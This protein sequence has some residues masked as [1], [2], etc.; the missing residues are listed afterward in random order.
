ML[1]KIIQKF[2]AKL[3]H[4]ALAIDR[5]MYRFYIADK[6]VF[7]NMGGGEYTW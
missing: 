1:K 6:Q 5:R 4:Y 2:I 3:Y 7:S